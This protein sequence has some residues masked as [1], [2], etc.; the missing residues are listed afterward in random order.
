MGRVGAGPNL[1]AN[2]ICGALRDVQN[3]LERGG[4]GGPAAADIGGQ[5]IRSK[6]ERR[7]E[8]VGHNRI[9][10]SY[11][12]LRF[13]LRND[14]KMVLEITLPGFLVHVAHPIVAHASGAAVAA[15]RHLDR[16]FHLIQ[17]LRRG[18]IG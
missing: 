14:D 4:I 18:D 12:S 3:G 6:S 11:A 16:R 17:F 9:H 8:R 2:R 1:F 13:D 15:R 10:V 5:I 7:D